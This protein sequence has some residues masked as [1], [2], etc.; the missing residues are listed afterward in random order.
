VIGFTDI[1]LKFTSGDPAP[2]TSREAHRDRSTRPIIASKI[3]SPL[4]MDRTR[5]AQN[6]LILSKSEAATPIW[7]S[8]GSLRDRKYNAT[9]SLPTGNLHSGVFG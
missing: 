6:P 7:R 1:E 8:A 3:P 5:C 2:D 9:R 4:E